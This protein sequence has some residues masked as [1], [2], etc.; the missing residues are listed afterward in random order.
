MSLTDG[1]WWEENQAGT[2]RLS[3]ICSLVAL[4]LVLILFHAEIKEFF[5]SHSWWENALAALAGI[6]VPVLA[7]FELLHSGEA[8]ELRRDANRLRADAVR[9]QERVAELED[10]KTRHLE[11]IAAN[12]RRPPK[13]ADRNV[14]ILRKH[15]RDRVSVSEGKS[16]WGTPPEIVVV[17]EDTVTLFTPAGHSS[18]QAWCVEVRFDDLEISEIPHGSCPLRLRVLKR[19][20]DVV[21]LNQISKWEDRFQAAAAPVFDKGGVVYQAGFN[22]PGS[23]ETRSLHIFASKD[24]RNEFLLEAST[25]ETVVGDNVEISKKFAIFEVDYR[26]A[27]FNRSQSGTGASPFPLFIHS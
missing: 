2:R 21:E 25:G 11:Q 16:S 20:G 22:K 6:A 7:Y 10:E 15:L 26:A 13:Q 4:A 24:S 3:A 17:G 23:P 19:Y 27:G 8:N 14:E 18:S 5:S 12:T 9:L 1:K